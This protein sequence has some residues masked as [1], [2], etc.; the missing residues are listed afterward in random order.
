MAFEYRETVGQEDH[1]RQRGGEGR[2]VGIQHKQMTSP[3]GNGW[4]SQSPSRIVARFLVAPYL[5]SLY[6]TSLKA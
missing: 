3:R 4:S 6:H 5:I 1:Q 2:A